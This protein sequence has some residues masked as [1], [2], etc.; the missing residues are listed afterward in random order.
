MPMRSMRSSPVLGIARNETTIEIE[1]KNA[2]ANSA[3]VPEMARTCE[4]KALNLLVRYHGMEFVNIVFMPAMPTTCESA[5]WA[6][7]APSVSLSEQFRMSLY[8]AM[9]SDQLDMRSV[10]AA[11]HNSNG[12][13]TTSRCTTM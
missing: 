7:S 8:D 9:L 13:A 3:M 10:V 2:S 5:L 11:T 4:G 6:M 1:R 12:T